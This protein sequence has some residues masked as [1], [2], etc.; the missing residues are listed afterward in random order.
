MRGAIGNARF[1]SKTE[2]AVLANRWLRNGDEKALHELVLAHRPLAIGM[3]KKFTGYGLQLD[4]LIQEGIIGLMIAAKRFDPDRGNR[5]STYATWWVR[6]GIMDFVLSNWS[7]IRTSKSRAAKLMFFNLDR[8]RARIEK[9]L[10]E[11]ANEDPRVSIASALSVT[12][13]DI[14]RMELHRNSRERSLNTPLRGHDGGTVE[15]QDLVADPSPSPEEAA[16]VKNEASANRKWLLEAL[17][18]LS[19]RERLIIKKRWMATSSASLKELGDILNVSGER[20][21][22]IEAAAISKLRQIAVCN[23]AGSAMAHSPSQ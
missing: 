15:I 4:D 19:A 22:Q 1:L 2:E 12:V 10:K 21:R 16:I 14:E 5:F 3:A 6:A 20:V 23:G 7:I 17:E 9:N 18:S 11:H 8:L 13:E